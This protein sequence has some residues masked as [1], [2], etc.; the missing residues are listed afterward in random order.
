MTLL[1]RDWEKVQ[2]KVF[3]RWCAKHLSERHIEFNTVEKD[4][5]DSTK[6]LNLLEI[7]GKEPVNG[8]KWHKAPKNRYQQLENCEMAI[9]YITQVK[10]NQTYWY[11]SR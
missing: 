11:S 1:S 4:F 5:S 10:K 9:N 3:S 6:L 8:G 7:I 2:I